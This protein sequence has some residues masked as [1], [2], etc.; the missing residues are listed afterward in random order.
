[1]FFN[2]FESIDAKNQQQQNITACILQALLQLRYANFIMQ[3]G[4]FIVAGAVLG[5]LIGYLIRKYL[6]TKKIKSAEAR[7]QDIV[8]KA[9]D[10]EKEIN[11][12]AKE[13]ALQIIIEI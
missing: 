4:I 3:A 6:V 10:K 11:I 13:R 2:Q 8:A 12:K 5:I 7:V 1:M 9:K